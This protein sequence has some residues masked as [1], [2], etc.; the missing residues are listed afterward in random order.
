MHL[1]RAY[2]LLNWPH[3]QFEREHIEW[4]RQRGLP[5][6]RQLGTSVH[7][8]LEMYLDMAESL[9]ERGVSRPPADFLV[10]CLHDGQVIHLRNALRDIHGRLGLDVGIDKAMFWSVGRIHAK[11][12]ALRARKIYSWAVYCDHAVKETR[13]TRNLWPY[14]LIRLVRRQG[15][16]WVGEDRDGRVVSQLTDKGMADLAD[17][18]TCPLTIMPNGNPV[19]YPAYASDDINGAIRLRRAFQG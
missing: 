11:P 2:S 17:A 14:R 8:L 13:L 7:M 12:D 9:R 16:G 15:D 4:S 5:G 1:G 6:P 18:T 3:V 19:T 10:V